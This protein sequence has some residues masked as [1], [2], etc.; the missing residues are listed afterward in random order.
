MQSTSQLVAI[1][2]RLKARGLIKVLPAGIH[3]PRPPEKPIVTPAHA[4]PVLKIDHRFGRRPMCRWCGSRHKRLP[5]GECARCGR[6][7]ERITFTEEGK[8][9]Q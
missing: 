2:E 6:R 4:A 7:A 1:V 5:G 3:P 9:L 8:Q